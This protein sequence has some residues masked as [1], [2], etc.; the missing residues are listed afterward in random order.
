MARG[1]GQGRGVRRAC[2]TMLLTRPV[3]PRRTTDN[4]RISHAAA[5]CSSR[6]RP[7]IGQ[8]E[9]EQNLSRG[10]K[11]RTTGGRRRRRGPRACIDRY[12][13]SLAGPRLH[14]TPF[15]ACATI[16]ASNRN[17]ASLT[18]RYST[19]A[20]ES[21]ASVRLSSSSTEICPRSGDCGCPES[22]AQHT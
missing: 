20:D 18:L 14:R 22:G 9:P 4:T 2:L 5:P 8:P 11:L 16:I 6:D 10:Y 15:R 19:D 3:S 12:R 1:R 17:G 13:A 21:G 7:G